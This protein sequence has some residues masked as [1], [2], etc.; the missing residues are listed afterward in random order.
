MDVDDVVQDE[1]DQVDDDVRDE[2]EMCREDEEV[3]WFMICEQH[4]TTVPMS[5]KSDGIEYILVDSGAYDHVCPLDWHAE[6]GLHPPDRYIAGMS[7]SGRSSVEA[8]W[9][10][11][12]DC[13]V[14]GWQTCWHS[15]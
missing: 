6:C 15:L 12:D 11:A 1:S 10:A 4:V 3:I 7:A 9:M 13:T 8:L 14:V 5:E 2:V